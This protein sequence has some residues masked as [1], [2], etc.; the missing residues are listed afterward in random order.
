MDTQKIAREFRLSEW[1]EAVKERI[2]GGQSVDA[3]CEE[4]NISKATYYYRQKKVREAACMEL[5][6]KQKRGTG[7]VPDGW[8]Q[9]TEAKSVTAGEG[10]LDIEIAG[11]HIL[12][13]AQTDLELLARVCRIL[14]SL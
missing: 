6:E 13:N 12:A 5:M 8:T 11:C 4:K 3:F 2:A 10:T 14:R 1:G 7:L 9:L